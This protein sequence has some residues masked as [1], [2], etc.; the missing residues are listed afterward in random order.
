[1]IWLTGRL[2]P[3]FKTIADFRKDNGVAIRK[4]CR[5]FV[6]LCRRFKLFADATVA[7]DRSKFKAVNK[8]DKNFTGRKLQARTEQLEQS[9]SRYMDE[10]DRVDRGPASLPDERI[11]HLKE[12]IQSLK[13]QVQKL[14][15]IEARMRA[16]PMTKSR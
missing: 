12:K 9:V 1:L 7:I 2:A 4:V 10:L 6:L 14:G 3:D 5:K 11:A 8:R 15:E 13:A 16:A